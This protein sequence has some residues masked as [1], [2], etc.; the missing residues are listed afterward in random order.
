MLQCLNVF[1][2]LD[3]MY[4]GKKLQQFSCYI[5]VN[6]V[7]PTGSEFYLLELWFEPK[8]LVDQKKSKQNLHF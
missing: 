1:V 8:C 4:P 2:H 6:P 5:V 7:R 3:V